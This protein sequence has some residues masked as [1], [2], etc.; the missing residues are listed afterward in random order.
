MDVGRIKPGH[1]A[2]TA[3]DKVSAWRGPR[4][5]VAELIRLQ[6]V[7]DEVVAGLAVFR[8]QTAQSVVSTY[9]KASRL[10]SLYR[11]DAVVGQAA[12]D[13]QAFQFALFQVVAQQT[14]VRTY[15]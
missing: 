12:L 14:V 3:K 11:C 5:T 9:P 8:V 2:Q 7:I 15:I 4:G 13:G 1:A 10:V 6:T